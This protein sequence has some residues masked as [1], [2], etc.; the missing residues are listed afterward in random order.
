MSRWLLTVQGRLTPQILLKN[1][2][3]LDAVPVRISS[4]V[5]MYLMW[6]GHLDA[7]GCPD[8]DVGGD[9]D[10]EGR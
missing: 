3:D 6:T 1:G 5:R 2:R 8:R 7:V 9:T 4:L 10:V